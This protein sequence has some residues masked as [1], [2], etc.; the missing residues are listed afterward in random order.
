MKIFVIFVIKLIS[1]V[2]Y[3]MINN[4]ILVKVMNTRYLIVNKC[5]LLNARLISFKN[6]SSNL[7]M[8]DKILLE[9][10]KKNFIH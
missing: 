4:V 9:K 2:H 5:I 7:T 8:K 10:K 6:K 3:I 1:T